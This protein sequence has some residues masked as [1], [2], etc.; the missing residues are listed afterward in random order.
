MFQVPALCLDGLTIV[1]SPLKSLQKDQ[2]D[3][4]AKRGIPVALINS[5]TGKRARTK[6]KQQLSDGTLKILYVSPETL[7]GEGFSDI[8]ELLVNVKL[9]AVDE[10]HCCSAWS[11]F[12][13]KYREIYKAREDYFP[14]A[15][16]KRGA[17]IN[18][19]E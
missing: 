14:D 18:F 10:A 2:V 6:L 19:F 4:C 13:P 5:D 17:F 7:F 15:V 16:L 1:I 9:L 11:D 8:M 12:R 3:N